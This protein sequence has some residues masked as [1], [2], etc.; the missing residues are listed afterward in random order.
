MKILVVNDDGI[1]SE[2]LKRLVERTKK[3]GEVFV[4]APKYNQSATSHKILV[5]GG[6]SVEKINLFPGVEAYAIDSTPADCVRFAHYHLKCDFD[7]VLSGVNKGYNLGFD[8]FYS[9]TVAGATE[10]AYT[11]RRGFALSA[12]YKSLAGFEK[13]FDEVMELLLSEEYWNK[14]LVYNVNFPIEPKGIKLAVQGD[15]CFDTYFEEKEGLYY[16]LGTGNL[17]LDNNE[18]SDAYLTNRGY[19]TITPL[20]GDRTNQEVY[21]LLKG[22]V[23]DGKR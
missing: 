18:N 2:G 9:G 22:G 21:N 3:Y 15:T 23:K 16:Q 6:F 1:Q 11:K 17:A 12:N 20:S 5:R 8:I 13:Y 19:V 14:A 4:V 10:A 7:L